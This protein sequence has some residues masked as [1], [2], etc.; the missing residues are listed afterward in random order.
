MSI[1]MMLNTEGILDEEGTRY[2]NPVKLNVMD[3]LGEL[4]S[5]DQVVTNLLGDVPFKITEVCV[6]VP[7]VF[8]SE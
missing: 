1:Y 4:W 7:F 5:T 8:I 2:N 3:F 6:C